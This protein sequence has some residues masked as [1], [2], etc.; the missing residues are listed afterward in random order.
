MS[1]HTSSFDLNSRYNTNSNKTIYVSEY[2]KLYDHTI[3]QSVENLIDVPFLMSSPSNGESKGWVEDDPQSQLAGDIHYYNYFDN[4]LNTTHLPIPRFASEF[5]FQS[6]PSLHT[7]RHAFHTQHVELFDFNTEHRQHLV[8]GNRILYNQIDRMFGNLGNNNATLLGNTL[9]YLSQL[10]QALCV[11]SLVS[12]FSRYYNRVLEDGRGVNSGVMFW[13]LNDVWAAPT[14]SVLDVNLRPK[15]LYYSIKQLYNPVV[16]NAHWN[17]THVVL[18][19][20]N[21]LDRA[22]TFDFDLFLYDAGSTKSLK[23]WGVRGT[24]KPAVATEVYSI[25][26]NVLQD[27]CEVLQKCFVAVEFEVKTENIRTVDI[28]RPGFDWSG[29]ELEQPSLSVEVVRREEDRLILKLQSMKVALWVWLEANQPGR[30]SH[31]FFPMYVP[32][33]FLEFV[34]HVMTEECCKVH[35]T[36]LYNHYHV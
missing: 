25:S 22:V 14:W 8:N 5:G 7:L 32:E 31:N 2:M 34:P 26:K 18:F 17:S 13:Q 23:E 28:T 10:N 15:M 20:V 27:N 21:R 11:S 3:R 1:Y 30:F 12:H 24:A 29:L 35:V 19:V 36:S 4:C 6:Y 16:G 9:V 33:M